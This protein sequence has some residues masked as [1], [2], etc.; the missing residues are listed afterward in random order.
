MNQRKSANKRVTFSIIIVNYNLSQDVDNCIYS[1]ID[2]FQ[3]SEYEI[4]VVDNKSTDKKFHLLTNKYQSNEKIKFIEN[5]ENNGFGAGNNLG[6][7]N[8]T[9]QFLY[10]LNPDTIITDNFLP[11]VEE[12]FN[13]NKKIAVIGTIIKNDDFILEHSAGYFPSYVSYL[14]DLFYLKLKIEKYLIS[15]RLEKDRIINVDWVSGASFFIR[16]SVFNSVGGFDERFFMY[17][18]EI[19]LCKRIKQNGFEIV[20]DSNSIVNHKGS[21][22]SKKDYYFFTKVSY[23]S[24]IYYISKHFNPIKR[25]IIKNIVFIELVIQLFC[26]SFMFFLTPQKAKGKLM[27]IPALLRKC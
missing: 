19:D 2:K 27:A 7:K 14:F 8:A 22:S 20:L 3:K 23:E 9:G 26:W 16:K 24:K 12:I 1:V 21:T 17:S 13:G 5:T 18:E 25:R 15:K 6:V 4:I 11:S 10:F